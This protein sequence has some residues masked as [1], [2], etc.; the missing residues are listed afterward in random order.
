[1]PCS[2]STR[3]THRVYPEHPGSNM[4]KKSGDLVSHDVTECNLCRNATGCVQL[5]K[6]VEASSFNGNSANGRER[7]LKV[8]ESKK[9][10]LGDE[11]HDIEI[12]NTIEH[13]EA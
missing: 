8:P 10:F 1:M 2:P 5:G 11:N 4:S 3:E 12:T 9:S 7:F 13:A 6:S